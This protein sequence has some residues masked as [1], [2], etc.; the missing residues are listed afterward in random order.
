MSFEIVGVGA[1]HRQIEPLWL[2]RG[3]VWRVRGCAAGGQATV[4]GCP[5]GLVVAI[6]P[7]PL[8]TAPEDVPQIGTIL[9]RE[10]VDPIVRPRRCR[11]VVVAADARARWPILRN[12]GPRRAVAI[13]RASTVPQVAT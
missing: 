12:R 8:R 5:G 1:S 7:V 2:G 4:G 6:S 10:D 9:E 3:Y 13:S 11:D